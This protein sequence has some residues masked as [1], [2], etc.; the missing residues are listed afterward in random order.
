MVPLH[1]VLPGLHGAEQQHGAVRSR[2]CGAFRGAAGPALQA[3][4]RGAF[5]KALQ[6]LAGCDEAPCRT[7]LG[8]MQLTGLQVTRHLDEAMR[9]FQ[10]AADEGDPEAQYAL[11]VLYANLLEDD[12]AELHKNEGLSVLYLYAASVAK[13]PGALMAMGY[14]HRE[15]LAVPQSCSTAAL[16]YIEVARQVAEVYS[17]GMPKAVELVRLGVEDD[18][19][20]MSFSK[21]AFVEIAASGDANVAAAVGKRYLL[22]VEGFPQ[23][24]ARAKSFLRTAMGQ[25]HPGAQGLLGYMYSLGLGV[26]KDLDVAYRFFKDAAAQDD[27]LGHNGLGFIFF[28]G[29]GT[30]IRQDLTMAFEHFNRSAHTGNADGMFN[31]ASVYLTGSGT[32]QSFQK[33]TQWYTQ[34]LDRGHTPAAY[35]LAVMHLNGIGTVRNCKLAVDLLKR[36]CERGSWVTEKLREA[37]ELHKQNRPDAA[38]WRFLSLAEAGHEVAQIN[39]AQ[40]FDSG[41]SSLL[42]NSSQPVAHALQEQRDGRF[43]GRAFAQRHYELSA[44]QGNAFS[45]LRLGDY[46]YY[47]WGL[48]YSDQVA[49]EDFESNDTWQLSAQETD[50]DL[51]LAH[52]RRTAT[53]RISGEWMQP[54][55]AR[56]S[57]NL[58][59]MYQFGVGVEQDLP[60]AQRFYG[61]SAEADP[62]AVQTPLAIMMAVLALQHFLAEVPE[63]EAYV[64]TVS[65]DVRFHIL[66]AHI[67]AILILV[68][69]RRIFAEA[70]ARAADGV[71]AT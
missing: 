57:F 60:L 17:S 29:T 46:A 27:P 19:H 20:Q 39:A 13:H 4:R 42:V 37:Q 44:E 41:Q 2:R 47:G 59:Y 30:T 56:A 16:N 54:F 12:P 33:A 1:E 14:R 71:Q 5:Q 45:E 7:L 8:E 63:L 21:M 43:L 3:M 69:M 26:P 67:C 55:V 23:D 38:A 31:L 24:F 9:H 53:M 61:Q 68:V 65:A 18:R 58:G 51:S 52:Y 36:V 35:A 34:A 62:G 64:A 66:L 49:E 48:R 70:R 50:L 40:L 32:E 15:G 10:A 25:R 6:K 22:G 11:G 28:Q